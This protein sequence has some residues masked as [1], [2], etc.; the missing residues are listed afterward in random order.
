MKIQ[1]KDLV[2]FEKEIGDKSHLHLHENFITLTIK[3]F[4]KKNVEEMRI[5]P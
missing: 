4:L 1:N 2:K 5:S 3:S